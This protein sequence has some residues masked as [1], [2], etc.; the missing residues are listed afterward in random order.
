MKVTSETF[1]TF[2]Q[3]VA[4]VE[5]LGFR[6]KAWHYPGWEEARN[7]G[8]YHAETLLAYY[9]MEWQPEGFWRDRIT[10]QPLTTTAIVSALRDEPHRIG[11]H[12]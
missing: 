11:G 6:V 1:L 5:G 12:Y 4:L 9:G 10:N 8:L 3:A 7:R 2:R